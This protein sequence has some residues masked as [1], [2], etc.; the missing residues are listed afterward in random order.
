M[1]KDA[2]NHRI[3]ATQRDPSQFEYVLSSSAP[4]ILSRGRSK[5]EPLES[6]A[7]SNLIAM[8]HAN[9]I[10]L[11]REEVVKANNDRDNEFIDIN[12]PIDLELRAL[13]TILLAM[14][15]PECVA[16][17]YVPGTLLLRLYQTNPFA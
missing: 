6:A 1:A 16:D 17:A 15:R 8:S 7:V 13:S 4:A 12:D 11:D 5:K 9:A 10:D 14:Q 3:T 2:K